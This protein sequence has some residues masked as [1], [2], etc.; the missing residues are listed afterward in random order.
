M[1]QTGKKLLIVSLTLT[2]SQWVAFTT[3]AG[4]DWKISASANYETGKYGTDTN[5]EILYLPL[6]VKRYFEIGDVSLTIPYLSMKSSSVVSIVDD[7]VFQIKQRAG[8]TIVTTN[9]GLGDIILKGSLYLLQ[10]QQKQPIDLS[11]VGKIKFPTADDKKGLGTGKYDETVGLEF[12]KL[13]LA[14]LTLLADAYYTFIGSP[15][16]TG[17]KNRFSFDTGLVDQINKSISASILY[18]ES[19]PL[20]SGTPDLRDVMATLEYKVTSELRVFAGGSIGLTG[21]SPDYGLTVGT[22]VRF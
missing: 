15:P 13:M 1:T 19:T 6:T 18:E 14:D 12:S 3:F 11:L 9:S 7:T 17:I 21:S 8:T 20:T 16:G 22:S 4:T 2:F 10:E 5:T